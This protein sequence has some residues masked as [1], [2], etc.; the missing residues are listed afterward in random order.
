MYF[1]PLTGSDKVAEMD[2]IIDNLAGLQ[3]HPY[4]QIYPSGTLVANLCIITKS[5]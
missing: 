1:V 3:L 4:S 5:S 2:F